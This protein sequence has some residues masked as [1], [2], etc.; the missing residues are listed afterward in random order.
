MKICH[1]SFPFR[2]N[3]W[4]RILEYSTRNCFQKNCF[5]KMADVPFLDTLPIIHRPLSILKAAI[6]SKSQFWTIL[7]INGGSLG[8]S[9]PACSFRPSPPPPTF[10]QWITSLVATFRGLL[11]PAGQIIQIGL[12]HSC[13]NLMSVMLLRPLQRSL[14]AFQASPSFPTHPLLSLA[15]FS[16]GFR[17]LVL[18]TSDNIFLFCS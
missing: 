1:F 2:E 17:S 11:I 7:Y 10:I 6:R 18:Q 13:P 3:P 12:L 5:R 14:V 15:Q 8:V 16:L 4:D 9:T